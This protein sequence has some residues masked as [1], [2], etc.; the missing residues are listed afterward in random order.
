MGPLHT[1]SATVTWTGAGTAGTAS[2]TSYSRNHEVLLPDKP[3]LLGTSDP[4]FRGE[5][6]RY[7]PEELFVTSLSQCHMLWFL[8]LASAEGITVT[9]YVDKATGRMRIES[10]GAGQFVDVT[11]R[12]RVTLASPRTR[13]GALVTDELV[14][15]VHEKAHQHCFIARSVNFP[16]HIDPVPLDR[17]AVLQD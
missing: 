2:Y 13:E 12:P 5:P 7:T 4:A 3:V 6:D 8:H 1:Y 16:V 10:Q 11:L 9:G 15:Q 14:A 17:V